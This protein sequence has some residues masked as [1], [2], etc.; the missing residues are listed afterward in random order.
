MFIWSFHHSEKETVQE[1]AQTLKQN[2]NQQLQRKSW[3]PVHNGPHT[4]THAPTVHTHPHSKQQKTLHPKEKQHE[5]HTRARTRAY[6]HTHIKHHMK[7]FTL[8]TEKRNTSE[9]VKGCKLKSTKMVKKYTTSQRC[10][11][12]A[13]KHSTFLAQ[14]EWNLSDGHIPQTNKH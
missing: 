9:H 3:S 8:S 7:Q 10:H 11:I 14:H 4:H 6:A 13:G 2:W 5:A 12:G 1:I